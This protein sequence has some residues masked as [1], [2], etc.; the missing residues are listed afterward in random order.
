M[1]PAA[2]APSPRLAQ[3]SLAALVALSAALAATLAARRL[4]G[5]LV[6]PPEFRPLLATA[7]VGL[8][9]AR[10]AR[11]IDAQLALRRAAANRTASRLLLALALVVGA[12][13][14]TQRG[15]DW[16]GLAVLWLV[17]VVEVV[18]VCRRAGA[19]VDQSRQ[20]APLRSSPP[21]RLFAPETAPPSDGEPVS[22]GEQPSG[23]GVAGAEPAAVLADEVVQHIVR[24]RTFSG[25]EALTAWLR[26]PLGP[27]QRGGAVHLAFCPPM[28]GPPRI[29]VEQVSGPPARLKTA[30]V[31]PFGARFEIKLAG[32][33][34]A[35]AG[36]SVVVRVTARCEPR[37]PPQPR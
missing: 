34:A 33:A 5:A 13:A 30:Q 15:A 23:G 21:L 29:E 25:G 26:M 18:G 9:L 10:A 11:W 37:Q 32:G 14:L 20:S 19:R 28:D 36:Q 1:N 8:L 16:R 17:A 6:Q 35:G 3:W 27:G 2:S 31:M 24:A 7:L 12:A 22:G 4:C